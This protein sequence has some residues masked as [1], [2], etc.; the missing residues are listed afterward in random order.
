MITRNMYVDDLITGADNEEEAVIR[1]KEIYNILL[2]SGFVL[3]K[4]ASNSKAVLKGIPASDR[5]CH[6]SLAFEDGESIKALGIRWY[7]ANDRFG[8]NV[9]LS[10]IAT[11]ITKRIV[12]ADTARLF[13]PLGLLSPVIIRA[14]I[15]LQILWLLGLDWDDKLPD[16]VTT[17][18]LAY[19]NDLCPLERI[20]IPRWL[21]TGSIGLT[22]ELHGFC[23]ASESAYAAVVYAR[24]V[25]SNGTIQV[26]IITSKTKVSP[27]QQITVPRLELCGATLLARLMAIVEKS[28]EFKDVRSIAWTDSMVVLAW[29]RK[30]PNNWKTFVANRVSHIQSTLEPLV[31]STC[32]QKKTRPIL[33]PVA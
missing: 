12:L 23:D 30:S 28:L 14:K 16:A 18:W 13:D 24:T 1:Q 10:S 31:G 5:E 9:T 17:Q 8:F 2:G 6:E 22:T 21:G 19:R 29:I 4:W 25:Y 15:L 27:V 7:P 11:P 26:N 3:R 20:R 33:R 32:P